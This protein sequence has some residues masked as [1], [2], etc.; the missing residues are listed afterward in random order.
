MPFG[1]CK[2]FDVLFEEGT[3]FCRYAGNDVIE[4]ALLC[5][6]CHKHK[7]KMVR[8]YSSRTTMANLRTS[9]R[10]LSYLEASLVAKTR[11]LHLDNMD[12]SYSVRFMRQAE[13]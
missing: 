9:R 13:A 2:D 8:H 5:P 6:L 4:V 11:D 3:P 12:W 1:N 10:A 7:S